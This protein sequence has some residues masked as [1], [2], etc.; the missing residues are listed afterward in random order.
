MKAVWKG[1][2]LAQS[3]ET[4]VVE[5]NHYFPPNTLQREY[6][7][8]SD[9]HTDCEW[10]GIASY[11]NVVVDGEVNKDAVWYYPETKEA[12]ANIQGYVAFWHGVEVVE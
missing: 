11:Y 6:V 2:T 12:A 9:T 1:V 3:D 10:K 4:V 5:T 7:Q 8:E